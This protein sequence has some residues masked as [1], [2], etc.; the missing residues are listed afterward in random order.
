[1]NNNNKVNQV[2]AANKILNMIIKRG[3]ILLITITVIA[4]CLYAITVILCLA[5]AAIS[6]YKRKSQARLPPYIGHPLPVSSINKHRTQAPACLTHPNKSCCHQC[7]FP[8]Q[9]S[10]QR[11]LPKLFG[12][13]EAGSRNWNPMICPS[14]RGGMMGHFNTPRATLRRGAQ[15]EVSAAL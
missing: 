13:F 3:R 4:Y 7:L 5:T 15:R 9:A 11:P 6:N 10:V 14:R 1:M 12:I 2:D 8:V